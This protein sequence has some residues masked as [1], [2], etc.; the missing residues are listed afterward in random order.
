MLNK[1]KRLKSSENG[2]AGFAFLSSSIDYFMRFDFYE[3]K[4]N[5][6]YMQID[7]SGVNKVKPLSRQLTRQILGAHNIYNLV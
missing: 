1:A 3:I 7:I 6:E 2:R 5:L 4:S